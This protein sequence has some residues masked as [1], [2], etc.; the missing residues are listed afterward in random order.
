MLRTIAPLL[1]LWCLATLLP[2]IAPAADWKK[3]RSEHFEIFTRES[4][5]N[6]RQVLQHLEQVRAAYQVLTQSKIQRAARGRVVL[7]KNKAEYQRYAPS[8]SDAFYLNARSRDYIVLYLSDTPTTR[9]LNHEYFHLFSRHAEF[10]FPPWLEEGMADFFSTLRITNKEIHMGLP[11]EEHLRY[12][13]S[14]SIT[15]IPLAR[16]FNLQRSERH[17][18]E[19]Q[20]VYQLYSQ[21]WALTH[22]TFL[23]GNM[24]TRSGEFL[25]ATRNGD[26]PEKVYQKIYGASI[27]DLE[28]LLGQYI[29]QRA[30]TYLKMPATGLDQRAQVE[31]SE[32]APWEAPLL[33]GHLQQYMGRADEAAAIFTDLARQYPKEPEIAEAQGYLALMSMEREAAAGHFRRAAEAGS[34]NPNLYFD[35]ASIGCKYTE[36]IPQCQQWINEAL[37]L[38]PN[39]VEARKWAVGY[40]LNARK[41]DHALTYLVRAGGVKAAD[42]PEYFFQYAYALANLDRFDE[43][44]GA[45]RRGLEFA[46]TEAQIARLRNLER[47]TETSREYRNQVT[48]LSTPQQRQ[49]NVGDD[50]ADARKGSGASDDAA[51]P[52]FGESTGAAE[53]E[54]PHI[55]RGVPRRGNSTADVVTTEME[56]FL[57]GDGAVLAAAVARQLDCSSPVTLTVEVRGQSLRLAIDDPQSVR[58]FVQ[59][60]AKTDHEFTCGPQRAKAVMVGYVTEGAPQGTDG[61][62]RILSF[63]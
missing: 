9:V 29:R 25:A 11:V 21:G 46:T 49:V 14:L 58:V 27:Q 34:T 56:A 31:E 28:K 19:K 41:F 7:L 44:R 61:V 12:L 6:A 33:L 35:L 42:A 1:T 10:Q 53:N 20:V 24:R 54:R 57:A 45:I 55:Q 3:F 60:E 32:I 52:E 47:L 17:Q 4:S 13:N 15:A 63:Q 40:V 43:A 26:D 37:R 5:G 22:M 39:Y 36:F 16:I 50:G 59:G 8:L 38:R 48:T 51:V 23:S 18:T 2:A 62:L 30:Y